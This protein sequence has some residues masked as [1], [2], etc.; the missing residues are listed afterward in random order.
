MFT[1]DPPHTDNEETSPATHKRI[2][3][4]SCIRQISTKLDCD[5][6]VRLVSSEFSQLTSN[7]SDL[8]GSSKAIIVTTSTVHKLYTEYIYAELLSNN[9]SVHMLVLN[10]SESSKNIQQVEQVCK[11]ALQ[12]N[13]G[14]DG[15]IISVGGGVVTD[16]VTVAASLIRR[17]VRCA[18]IPTTLIGQI[19]AAIGI[20]GA[21]NFVNNK[22]Y[23][24]CFYA[25][26]EV[27]VNPEFLKSLPL[28][29]LRYGI[30]EI[31]KLGIVL[32]DRLFELVESF[33][34]D[35]IANNF[36]NN[37][38]IRDEV[39]WRSIEGMMREL[40][41][42]LFE[43]QTYERLVDFGHTFSPLLESATDFTLAHGEAVAIDMALSVAISNELGLISEHNRD[44]IIGLLIDL[45]L[46]VYSSYLTLDLCKDSIAAASLHRAGNPN[47]VIPTEIGK[48]EFIRT[49]QY[50]TDDV[51][52]RALNTVWLQSNL[53]RSATNSTH[54]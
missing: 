12:Q 2:A 7:L 16:I 32:D 30:S 43:N 48:G 34:S 26:E 31:L 38:K 11:E 50:L 6:S 15:I 51:Y 21:V 45:G 40:E 37:L 13:I 28:K 49:D 33:G 19:D 27:I 52:T 36:Q 24:G 1:T 53:N 8:I 25:P 10:C 41:G 54:A 44:R 23:I 29:H 39:L 3:D 14:R 9:I 35:L 47:L 4:S 22:S 46:P 17:G 5:Y 18:R 20:K 42:N